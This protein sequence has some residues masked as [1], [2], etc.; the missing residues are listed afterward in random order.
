MPV[1]QASLM[2]M[3]VGVRKITELIDIPALAEIVKS[4]VF[5]VHPRNVMISVSPPSAWSLRA[6]AASGRLIGSLVPSCGRNCKCSAINT[7][8]FAPS[9]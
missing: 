6:N 2:D 4:L 7:T 5:I 8:D 9:T 3:E 1:S